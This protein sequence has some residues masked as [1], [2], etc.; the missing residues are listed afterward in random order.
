MKAELEA[1]RIRLERYD[2]DCTRIM[3][4]DGQVVALI[5]RL[6]NERWTVCV[7]SVR[8]TPRQF[9]TIRDAARW[10]LSRP[11]ATPPKGTA[12]YD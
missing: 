6:A 4:S 10:W 8:Q 3:D 7:G 2:K 9:A 12:D 5:E 1:Q 11:L